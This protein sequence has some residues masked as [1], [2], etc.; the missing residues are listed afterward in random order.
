MRDQEFAEELEELCNKYGIAISVVNGFIECEE[1]EAGQKVRVTRAFNE[2][3]MTEVV[4]EF[5]GPTMPE[6]VKE[7][8]VYAALKE[9]SQAIRA[10]GAQQMN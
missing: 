4:S 7:R 3:Y 1:I 5:V 2:S 10:R 9:E 8:R 6:L